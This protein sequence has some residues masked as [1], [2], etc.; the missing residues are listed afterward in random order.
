MP[1][2]RLEIE[3]LSDMMRGNASH[4]S[5]VGLFMLD[6][7]SAKFNR[8]NHQLLD[9]RSKRTGHPSQV[10]AEPQLQEPEEAHPHPAMTIGLS[11]EFRKE[12]LKTVFLL[13]VAFSCAEIVVRLCKQTCELNV[14]EGET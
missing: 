4:D 6:K 13:Y 1:S 11:K 14:E 3:V 7:S 12:V 10:H 8:L 5:L 2:C 9:T